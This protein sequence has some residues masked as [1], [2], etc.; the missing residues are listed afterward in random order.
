MDKSR[1][2]GPASGRVIS[3]FDRDKEFRLCGIFFHHG[4]HNY[5]SKMKFP[6]D[7]AQTYPPQTQLRSWKSFLSKPRFA[8]LLLDLP[9]Y[10][11]LCKARISEWC[12]FR[13]SH[14]GFRDVPFFL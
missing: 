8:Y 6:A 10:I 9:R 3:P 7:L 13:T 5:P 12:T 14:P 2:L 1:R 11:I 4:Y